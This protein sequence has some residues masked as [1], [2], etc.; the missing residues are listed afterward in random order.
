MNKKEFIHLSF[1]ETKLL[2]LVLELYIG[3]FSD[4]HKKTNMDLCRNLLKKLSD[5]LDKH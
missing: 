4:I 2:E 1:D 5:E 3:E